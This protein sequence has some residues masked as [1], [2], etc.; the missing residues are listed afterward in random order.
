MSVVITQPGWWLDHVDELVAGLR[1]A[2][3]MPNET[4]V[5]HGADA[6][7]IEDPAWAADHVEDLERILR[8]AAEVEQSAQQFSDIDRALRG[9]YERDDRPPPE[10]GHQ[11]P[12]LTFDLDSTLKDARE[13]P[14]PEPEQDRDHGI[15]Q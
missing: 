10:R 4:T 15:D 3:E 5:F 13:H 11:D 9:T 8:E 7:T 2:A 12:D 14:P 6:V 1:V